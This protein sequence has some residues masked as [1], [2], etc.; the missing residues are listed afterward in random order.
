MKYS[1]FFFLPLLLIACKPYSSPSPRKVLAVD[2]VFTSGQ[3]E[4]YGRY[5]SNL[6]RNVCSLTLV[7]QGITI[8]GDTL[9]GTGSELV[10]TDIFLPLETD[11][12][13][14]GTYRVDSTAAAFSALSALEFEGAVTGTYLLLLADGLPQRLYMFPSGSFT[15]RQWEDTTDMEIHLQTLDSQTFDA[16]FRGVIQYR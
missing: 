4:A 12:L 2:T 14:E 8:H 16:T 1:L 3:A 13:P 11:T 15:L 9:S 7:S 6:E 5:Y 10:F